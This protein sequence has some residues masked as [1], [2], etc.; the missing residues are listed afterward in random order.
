MHRYLDYLAAAGLDWAPRPLGIEGDRERL[1][2]IDDEV[3]VYPFPDWV[4]SD[5][6]VE[7][8]ARRRVGLILSAYGSYCT[9]DDVV[10][11]AII[12]L[13]DLAEFSIA[14]AEE[15]GKPQLL[16]DAAG[17]ERDTRYRKDM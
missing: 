3:P 11:V 2:P 12:R 8:G 10:R 1:S 6:V 17:Y 5:A 14:K 7:Y 15:L 13:N 9:W 16:Q 4:W